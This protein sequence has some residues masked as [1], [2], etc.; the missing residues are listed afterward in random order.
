MAAK[1]I[2]I[3][4][5]NATKYFNYREAWGKIARS[6]GH[7]FYVEAV[8]LEES[9]MCDRLLSY[10]RKTGLVNESDPKRISF[11]K[12]VQLLKEHVPEPIKD[13]IRNPRFENLQDSILKWKG[14][15]NHVIHG[16]VKSPL[17]GND[18]DVLAF[19]R[20]AEETAREGLEIAKSLNNWYRRYKDRLKCKQTRSSRVDNI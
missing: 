7:G 10:F 1:I 15:R 19:N 18:I 17:D 13:P 20:T 5:Q 3:P 8:A 9:V 16:I 6:I 4:E 14:K 2:L 11:G 12:L